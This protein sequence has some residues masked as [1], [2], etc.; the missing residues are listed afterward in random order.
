MTSSKKKRGKQR[1]AAKN[2][3]AAIAANNDSGSGDAV[4]SSRA[5]S[6]PD[7][8]ATINLSPSQIVALVQKGNKSATEALILS[9]D[10]KTDMSFEI[11]AVLPSVLGF[12]QK[13]EH[14]TFGKVIVGIGGDLSS[15]STWIR[16]LLRTSMSKPSCCM[17]IAEN[18]G[19][20]V[21]CM[22]N[23]SKRLFFKSNKHWR[24]SIV[25]FVGLIASMVP[26]DDASPVEKRNII[27]TL[28]PDIVP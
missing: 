25:S 23:D 8:Y 7:G 2:L 24:E 9:L 21:R 20:V 18:I 22:C 17:Q 26:N 6:I 12:L 28:L 11:N 10:K 5:S 14:E 27:D 19:P 3:A 1:K 15:P 4:P 16:L 13:C